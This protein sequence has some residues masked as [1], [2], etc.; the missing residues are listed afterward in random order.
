MLHEYIGE[1]FNYIP[2][3]KACRIGLVCLFRDPAHIVVRD[4]N[5]LNFKILLLQEENHN[6]FKTLKSYISPSSGQKKITIASVLFSE[7]INTP[8][9][10][11][12]SA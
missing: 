11:K 10:N 12:K 7:I 6:Y 2:Q 9:T 3:Y 5:E 1:L 8:R 4:A